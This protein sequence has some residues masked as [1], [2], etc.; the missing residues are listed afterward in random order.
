MKTVPKSTI[1][2]LLLMIGIGF[3]G[4]SPLWSSTYLLFLEAQAIASYQ[5]ASD[6]ILLYSHHPHEVM[7][8]PAL[9]VDYVQRLGTSKGDFGLIAIQARVAYNQDIEPRL[10]AQLYNAYLKYK[11]P[12]FD[13]WA[14]HNKPAF[15]L[16]TN[17]DNH[18]A[19]L[20]DLA[21]KGFNF[22]RDWG[23]GIEYEH[24]AVNWDSSISTGSGMKLMTDGSYLFSSR[25]GLYDFSRDDVSWGFS[26]RKGDTLEAMGYHI[27][28]EGKLHP[29]YQIGLDAALR[30]E[31]YE[32]KTDISVGEFMQKPTAAILV[33]G[34]ALF[35][36]EERFTID[37]QYLG[38]RKMNVDKHELSLGLGYQI[39]P[40]LSARTASV[41]ET[42]EETLGFIMQLYYYNTFSS[43]WSKK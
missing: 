24:G 9:G 34:T 2:T 36:D 19:I 1:A 13:I 29:E 42:T 27:M 18:S 8:K 6:K 15:G 14:G 26:F 16:N 31:S 4:V 33:R 43:L 20:S 39:T 35:T 40:G 21:M 37:T 32:F 10:E 41:Y 11:A 22:D 7:Q 23:M 17:L 3:Y 30:W 25:I 38:S 28:H 12:G 5:E